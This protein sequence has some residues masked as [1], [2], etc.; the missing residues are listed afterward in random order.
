MSEKFHPLIIEPEA[1]YRIRLKQAM[2][3]TGLFNPPHFC[4]SFSEARQMLN[5]SMLCDVIFISQRVNADGLA[6]FLAFLPDSHSGRE[7]AI[8]GMEHSSNKSKSAVAGKMIDGIHGILFEPYS[9][10][11][12]TEMAKLAARVRFAH[13]QTKEKTAVRL[14]LADSLLQVDKIA[15][16]QMR[17]T[18]V[19]REVSKLQEM[20][21]PLAR[22]KT[23]SP[24][25]YRDIA[26][27][28]F[29]EAPIPPS[30]I[31]YQPYGGVSERLQQKLSKKQGD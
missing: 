22:L 27:V 19:E 7:C 14:L 3:V 17:G 11:D 9:V 31:S 13:L 6:A 20:C 4:R 26:S 18:S 29:A 2:N 8:I 30:T 15:L 28:T 1:T 5:S 25:I 16:G 12:V 10:Q 24:H 21:A 23:I